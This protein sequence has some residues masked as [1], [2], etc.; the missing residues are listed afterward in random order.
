MPERHARRELREVDEVE[1]PGEA[2]VVAALGLLEALE[3]L[4]EILGVVEGGSVDPRQ[5][6]LR[7][8]AAPVGAGQ[9]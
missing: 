3:V 2:A 4:L 8:V 9:G 7:L 1:L 6:W 5:L